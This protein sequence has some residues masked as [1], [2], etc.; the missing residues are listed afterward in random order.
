MGVPFFPW[1]TNAGN[2]VSRGDVL[3]GKDAVRGKSCWGGMVAFDARPFQA[4]PSLRFGA[5]SDTYWDAS[6]CCLIHA[7]IL[8]KTTLDEEGEYV[9][10]YMNPIVRPAYSTTTLSWIRPVQRF[11]RLF[12]IPHNIVNHVV[13]LPWVNPRRTEVPGSQVT[14]KVWVGDQS[15]NAGGSFEEKT[16]EATVGGFCG[17]RT[18]QLIKESQRKGEKNWETVDVPPR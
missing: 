9:G 4:N 7:D 5:T 14:E 17:I 11:E 3:A 18:L 13:G 15:L 8:D 12:S 16:Q 10:I 2:G 1:F 6:E